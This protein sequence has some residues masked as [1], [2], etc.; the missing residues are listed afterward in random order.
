MSWKF[1]FNVGDEVCGLLVRGDPSRGHGGMR[2]VVVKVVKKRALSGGAR[3]CVKV[4]WDS[5]YTSSHEDVQL[6]RWEGQE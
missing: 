3:A 5:G 2:G 6:W 4:R 1:D